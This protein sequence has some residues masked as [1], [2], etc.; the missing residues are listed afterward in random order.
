MCEIAFAR[1]PTYREPG[2][3][4]FGIPR[5]CLYIKIRHIGAPAPRN[6]QIIF[7]NEAAMTDLGSD[8]SSRCADAAFDLRSRTLQ[9]GEYYMEWVMLSGSATHIMVLS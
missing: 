7:E 1:S 9:P 5:H 3:P 2:R 8:P 4:R 6:D